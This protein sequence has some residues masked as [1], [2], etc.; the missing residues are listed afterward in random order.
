MPADFEAHSPTYVG[1]DIVGGAGTLRQIIARPTALNPY[2][3][4][5]A[6]M[7]LCSASTRRV[8]GP[9]VCLGTTPPALR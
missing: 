9:T 3:T 7:Y 2:T 4:G 6:R 1:G 5:V 8:R